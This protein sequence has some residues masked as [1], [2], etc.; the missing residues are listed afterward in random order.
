ML[1]L[2]LLFD[3][4]AQKNKH[5]NADVGYS[6]TEI[7]YLKNIRI[8]ISDTD[9]LQ[10]SALGLK[11]TALSNLN[12]Y[13]YEE[14]SEN[15][16]KR[17]ENQGYPFASVRIV[18]DNQS[19]SVCYKLAVEKGRF[20]R[21]DSIVLK[22]NARVR[23]S[24]LW[25]YLGLKRHSAYREK[26]VAG[27]GKK[28]SLLPFVTEIQPAGLSFLE[29]KTLLYI[30]LDKKN[31]NRFDGYIGF[32]PVSAATG[33]FSVTGEIQLAL[34]NIMRIGESIALSWHSG[35]RHSQYLSIDLSFPYLFYTRFGVDAGFVLDKQDT[36]YLTLSYNIGVPYN[37]DNG[38]YIR[39]YFS[40][41]QSRTLAQKNME[42][43]AN[44]S[45]YRTTLY[46]L[47]A[48]SSMLDNVYKPRR[49]YDLT[50]N[51]SLGRRVLL[52]GN[53]SVPVQDDEVQ[54]KSNTYKIHGNVSGY[55]PV[56]KHF[57]L[58]LSAKAGSLLNGP[59]FANEMFKIGGEGYLR[60]FTNN[61]IAASTYL[62]CGAEFR[63][64]F[65]SNSDLHFFFD[66]GAYENRQPGKYLMDTPF[67]FG[68]GVNIGV[69]SGVFYFEYALP[70][71]FNN[72]ISF[73]TGKIHFGVK[74]MF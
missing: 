23:E 40:Y 1:T 73:K 72:R 31:T 64:N 14:F 18:E 55:I 35:E 54:T 45:D 38:N 9:L 13:V 42:Q 66:G 30:Y 67:G 6:K 16:L 15:V 69:R 65:A 70:R 11:E 58:V 52:N 8:D 68:I 34:Q 41:S 74:A 37:I 43:D 63:Y 51:A 56:W 19:D 62:L 29:D 44:F 49:G 17:L 48:H 24:F 60:G 3:A 4:M 5:R 50:V 27:I 61:E 71:Q 57:T 53:V 36:T 7:E 59:H 12:L 10:L 22:G 21:I 39:P 20:V 2:F 28:L 25:P 47:T 26:S 32:Q 46:G 33:K